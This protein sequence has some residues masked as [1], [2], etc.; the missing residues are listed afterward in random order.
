MILPESRLTIGNAT[1][2]DATDQENDHTVRYGDIIFRSPGI[3]TFTV[4]ETKPESA[5]AI[6]GVHYSNAQFRVTV[7]VTD[8]SQDPVVKITVKGSGGVDGSIDAGANTV[9]FINTY[10]APVTA[11]PLTGG[12]ATARNLILAGGGILLLAGV[13]WLLA[14]R[15]RV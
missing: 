8:L 4:S 10:V 11:L 14:R 1:D 2:L 9:T 15:R 6:E 5:E 7:N 13:A 3:Y 12:D